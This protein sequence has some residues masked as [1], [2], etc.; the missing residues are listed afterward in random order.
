MSA[1]TA[2]ARR[3]VHTLL[4]GHQASERAGGFFPKNYDPDAPQCGAREEITGTACTLRAGHQ[5]RHVGYWDAHQ[6]DG[7]SW[8]AKPAIHP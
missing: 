2:A 8:P 5:D 1:I 3:V 4:N 7:I 6:A